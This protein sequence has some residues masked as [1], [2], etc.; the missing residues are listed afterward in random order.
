MM[1]GGIMDTNEEKGILLGFLSLFETPNKDGKLGAILITDHNG[2]PQEFRCSHPVK[3]TAIQKPLYGNTLE[4][5]VGIQLC[6][7]PLIQ[8]IKLKP[9][10]IIVDKEFLLKVRNESPFPVIFLHRAGETM[11]VESSDGSENTKQ[12]LESSTGTFQPVIIMAH[13]DYREDQDSAREIIE[14]IFSHLDP[15]EP[16]ER[17]QKAIEVLGKQDNRFQ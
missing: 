15:Y 4:P 8:S 2:V 3:P 5:Y 9:N 17:M 12:R 1:H 6:G 11:E 7:I 16:F 14:D 10:L 13:S